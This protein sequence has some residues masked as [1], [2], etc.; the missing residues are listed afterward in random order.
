[1]S[2]IRANLNKRK[3]DFTDKT[4]KTGYNR[5]TRKPKKSPLRM[6]YVLSAI[7]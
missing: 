6:P 5:E 1:L 2:H 3:M 4:A 7:K